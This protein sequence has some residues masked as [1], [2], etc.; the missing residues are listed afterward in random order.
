M[1]KTIT[2]AFFLLLL[3]AFTAEARA[4]DTTRSREEMQARIAAQLAEVQERLQLTDE[5]AGQVRPILQEGMQQRRALLQQFQEAHGGRRYRQALRRLRKNLQQIQEETE[6]K[7]RPVLT[8][9]QMTEYRQIQDERRA[10]L[11]EE[12]RQRRSNA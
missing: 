3:L 12:M 4:Q 11:R 5:Q 9:E 7:L 6:A 1:I 10:R 2:H 8:E